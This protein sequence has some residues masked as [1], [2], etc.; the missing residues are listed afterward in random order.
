MKN[1]L[2]LT[3]IVAVLLCS[4][5]SIA[6]TPD[7]ELMDIIRRATR[8]LDET[9]P[10]QGDELLNRLASRSWMVYRAPGV[11]G[12]S[13]PARD[14][15]FPTS[16]GTPIYDE[17]YWRTANRQLRPTD[18]IEQVWKFGFGEW[19]P[20]EDRVFLGVD[21]VT[22]RSN[23]PIQPAVLKSPDEFRAAYG[24]NF[25]AENIFSL[26]QYEKKTLTEDIEI[27]W[28]EKKY[29]FTKGMEYI[30]ISGFCI[31]SV[32][33]RSGLPSLNEHRWEIRLFPL[34]T[35]PLENDEW[36]GILSDMDRYVTRIHHVERLREAENNRLGRNRTH[37]IRLIPLGDA[38]PQQIPG[39]KE[40]ESDERVR[41]LPV[42]RV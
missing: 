10:D 40:G 5:A 17:N 22:R 34:N 20:G 1:V 16:G 21:Q 26:T 42:M 39:E 35:V 24:D 36:L 27:E 11:S 6:L 15:R 9:V 18:S 33:S 14:M 41:P 7:W 38:Q 25:T 29:P 37:T 12:A 32:D 8:L 28:Q 19:R 23:R 2:T 4:P 3:T 30:A 31:H 13:P